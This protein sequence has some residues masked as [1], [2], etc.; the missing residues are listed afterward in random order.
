MQ[1]RQAHLTHNPPLQ[2]EAA[3]RQ[4]GND[5]VDHAAI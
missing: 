2:A 4:L 3:V 5:E 1:N